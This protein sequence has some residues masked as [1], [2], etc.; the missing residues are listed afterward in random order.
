MSIYSLD[1][2]LKKLRI[3]AKDPEKFNAIQYRLSRDDRHG[4]GLPAV[5]QIR[6]D[7]DGSD[8]HHQQSRGGQVVC[9]EHLTPPLQVQDAGP[10]PRL[11]HRVPFRLPEGEG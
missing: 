7:G 4:V 3:G 5:S 10:E 11:Q 1:Q 6:G 2:G 8:V 9:Q